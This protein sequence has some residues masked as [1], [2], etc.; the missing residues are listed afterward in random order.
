MELTFYQF[1]C[2]VF[3][4]GLFFLGLKA[5]I[6]RRAALRL[7]VIMPYK[8]SG[9]YKIGFY[10]KPPKKIKPPPKVTDEDLCMLFMP[11]ARDF[12]YAC[13]Q[14]ERGID[15][16]HPDRYEHFMTEEKLINGIIK[17]IRERQ[18]YL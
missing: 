14:R 8:F 16:C 11:L 10:Q 1:T 13:R 2:L 12:Q 5:E 15:Y 18:K 7:P 4:S 6:F 17:I 3:A 9:E